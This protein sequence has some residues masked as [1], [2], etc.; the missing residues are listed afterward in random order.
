ME[1]SAIFEVPTPVRLEAAFSSMRL[2]IGKIPITYMNPKLF[3]PV[4]S[5]ESTTSS[6][7]RINDSYAFL[8]LLGRGS[9]GKVY[10]AVNAAEKQFAVKSISKE[11]CSPNIHVLRREIAIMKALDHVNLVRFHETY[12]DQ[13]SLHVVMELAKGRNLSSFIAF[14]AKQQDSPLQPAVAA[15]HTLERTAKQLFSQIIRA[16][17]YLHS[18]GIAHRDLKPDNIIVHSTTKAAIST[19]HVKII[20]FGL[21]RDLQNRNPKS[22]M[23]SVGTPLFAAPEMVLNE[24]YSL[25]IDVWSIGVLLYHTLSAGAY[26]FFSDNVKEV[27]HK[28][29]SDEPDF[30]PEAFASVSNEAKNFIKKLL[31]KNG[32]E[33]ISC[34]EALQDSWLRSASNNSEHSKDDDSCCFEVLTNVVAYSPAGKLKREILKVLFE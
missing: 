8:S 19:H 18:K 21:S 14:I 28:I 11:L 16:I 32:K 3:L 33:R 25:K 22:L 15:T 2:T 4:P 30:S 27:F 12:H 13:T 9:F 5:V 7:L 34:A 6:R 31:N 29:I 1:S 23:T 10:L 17:A 24:G 20:D 26:P